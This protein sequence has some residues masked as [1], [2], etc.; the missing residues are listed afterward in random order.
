M[1]QEEILVKLVEGKDGQ[2]WA[3]NAYGWSLDGTGMFHPSCLIIP[4]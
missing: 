4:R 1:K 2:K 3:T